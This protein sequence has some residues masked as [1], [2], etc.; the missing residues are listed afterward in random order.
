MPYN[1]SPDNAKIKAKM[2]Y[3]S[4]RDALRRSLVG[5]AVEV[6]GTDLSEVAFDCEFQIIQYFSYIY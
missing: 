5:I 4:S 3:A 6:Q 1:R 2:V